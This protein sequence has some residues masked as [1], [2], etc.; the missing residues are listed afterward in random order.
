MI[1]AAITL[2]GTISSFNATRFQDRLASRLLGSSGT[3]SDVRLQKDLL[4]TLLQGEA[5]WEDEDATEGVRADRHAAVWLA[6]GF[7]HTRVVGNRL[8]ATGRWPH[9]PENRNFEG[10]P[11]AASSSSAIQSIHNGDYHR[12]RRAEFTVLGLA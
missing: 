11:P 7:T 1:S 6:P 10:A 12:L 2:E 3:I 4:L 9:T 8:Q 5:A